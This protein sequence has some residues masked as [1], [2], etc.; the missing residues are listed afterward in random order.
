MP[1][2]P[3]RACSRSSSAT[4]TVLGTLAMTDKRA[5][6]VAAHGRV[7][8]GLLAHVAG[9]QEERAGR[10]GPVPHPLPAQ[11]R[12]DVLARQLGW[13]LLRRACASTTS[14]SR[15]VA[16]SMGTTASVHAQLAGQAL[17]RRRAS[18]PASG[19]SACRRRR[20]RAG[21]RL[22]ELGGAPG[23]QQRE[24]R[25]APARERDA[26]RRERAG[27]LVVALHAERQRLEQV[28]ERHVARVRVAA[29]RLAGRK[30]LPPSGTG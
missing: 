14:I 4:T 27:L 21:A 22:D 11:P 15:S 6:E 10:V 13:R 5:F 23:D 16:S 8:D 1:L 7:A 25:V 26:E 20:S 29:C 17:G 9:L 28:V 18:R 24:H 12:L 2:K 19:G 30:K 3:N